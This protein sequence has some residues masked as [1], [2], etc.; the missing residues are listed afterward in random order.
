MAKEK[1]MELKEAREMSTDLIT[2]KDTPIY[3]RPMCEA[4]MLLDDRVTALEE[5]LRKLLKAADYTS[6][7]D[8]SEAREN[9]LKVLAKGE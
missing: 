9:A 4:L 7:R 8:Y 5:A 3:I 6:L 1:V 2:V